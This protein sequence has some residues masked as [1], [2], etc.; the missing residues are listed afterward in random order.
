MPPPWVWREN[1]QIAG[2]QPNQHCQHHTPLHVHSL[3]FGR[4]SSACRF[5][6]VCVCVCEKL[7]E[8]FIS[9]QLSTSTRLCESNS[10]AHIRHDVC[11]T[12]RNYTRVCS[13]TRK[14]CRGNDFFF[15]LQ[16]HRKFMENFG[17]NDTRKVWHG[18]KTCYT[19]VT[20]HVNNN[21]ISDNFCRNSGRS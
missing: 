8:Y 3:D 12:V 20:V 17:S 15:F 1:P 11:S 10:T 2:G 18:V 5:S 21:N 19:L 4:F 13:P 6:W 14:Q 9:T 7:P 16:S